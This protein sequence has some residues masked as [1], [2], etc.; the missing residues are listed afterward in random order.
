MTGEVGI[1][2]NGTSIRCAA[3]STVAAVLL[4]RDYG[5]GLR[6]SEIGGEARGLFC[7]MGV[8]FDCLVTIDGRPGQRA[9]MAIVREGMRI[10]TS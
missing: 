7:G 3:A 10:E 8:C 6:K 9:C 4:S 5:P 1:T 2:V